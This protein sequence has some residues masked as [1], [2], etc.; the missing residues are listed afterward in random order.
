MKRLALITSL[1]LAAGFASAQ[2]VD[3]EVR[4]V[5]TAQGKLTLKHGEIKNL[6]MPPMTM[7]F[8]VANKTMLDGLKAGDKVKVDVDKIDG[9]YTVVRLARPS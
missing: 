7:V 2:S 3:A 5:D 1:A 6:D 9:Q 8:R 4:K